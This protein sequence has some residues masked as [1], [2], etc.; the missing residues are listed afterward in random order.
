MFE[1]VCRFPREISTGVK[2]NLTFLQPISG[3]SVIANM[4]PDLAAEC[5]RSSHPRMHRYESLMQKNL[6]PVPSPPPLCILWVL[7]QFAGGF[8][9][10]WM[11]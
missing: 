2:Q 7:L 5:D 11:E 4:A 6:L 3:R 8:C 10:Q 1:E 9:Y